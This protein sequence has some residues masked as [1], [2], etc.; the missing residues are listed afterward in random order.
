MAIM[1]RNMYSDV[2]T[3]DMLPA[4][5][6]IIM[7]EYE[8]YPSV[9][10]HVYNVEK[11][12]REFEQTTKFTGFGLVPVK[13]EGSD[14]DYDISYQGFDKTYRHDTYKL[15]FSTTKEM[16]D[17]DKVGLVKKYAKALGRS[18]SN[19][20]EILGA[21]V[22]NTAFSTAGPDGVSLINT[23]HPH[24][25]G[26]TQSNLVT[27]ADLS[28]TVLRDMLNTMHGLVDDRGLRLMI[29]PKYLLVPRGEEQMAE[30]LLK[31]RLKPDTAENATNYFTIKGLEYIVW[32]YL[33]DEDATFLLSEPSVN[34][35]YWFNREAVNTT[36]DYDFDKDAGK[37]K[38]RWRGSCG[39]SDY[40][41][42]V[43]TQGI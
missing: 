9:I 20:Q 8:S 21:A 23:S 1:N 13:T 40:L 10:P 35:L 29:K 17:D 32:D 22:F 37:T 41:W 14:V 4:I 7:E 39:Y 31:S 30:E 12:D 19:T 43:G 5:K 34:Q 38:I 42:C 27:A 36:G 24:A 28:F 2:F 25:A 3:T 26:G 18:M 6:H 16:M 15:G 33:T 11:S